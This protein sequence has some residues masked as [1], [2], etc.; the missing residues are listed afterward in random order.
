M[1]PEL[2]DIVSRIRGS[3]FHEMKTTILSWFTHIFHS[4]IG[5][6]PSAPPTAFFV[7]Q[8]AAKEAAGGA[9]EA[10]GGAE[11]GSS[12]RPCRGSADLM[13]FSM[14]SYMWWRDRACGKET[15][16]ALLEKTCRETY[17]QTENPT[18]HLDSKSIFFSFLFFLA[19]G[20]LKITNFSYFSGVLLTM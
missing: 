14:L 10:T 15:L 19:V 16:L 1:F 4:S 9:E 13:P 17:W 6:A 12:G 8:E 20:L 5:A 2:G 11:R 7:P 3:W 18:I